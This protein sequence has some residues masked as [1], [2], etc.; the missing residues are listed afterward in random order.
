MLTKLKYNRIV[1]AIV[2]PLSFEDSATSLLNSKKSLPAL[3]QFV[4]WSPKCNYKRISSVVS[5]LVA[6]ICVQLRRIA[7]FLLQYH[8]CYK[9]NKIKLKF[10]TLFVK[11][12][13]FSTF[14]AWILNELSSL[15]QSD[16]LRN[17][18]TKVN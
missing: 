9:P 10:F 1:G 12:G 7:F 11:E 13:N 18:I 4:Y 8:I 3:L 16:R 5:T 15:A 14:F 17:L 2:Y 6:L